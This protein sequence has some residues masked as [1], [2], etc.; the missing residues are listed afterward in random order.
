[1]RLLFHLI[2]A[3]EYEHAARALWKVPA[4]HGNMEFLPA[5]E[6]LLEH[7][8]EGDVDT[9]ISLLFAKSAI[10]FNNGVTDQA[11]S[12]L[13]DIINL[14]IHENSPL[15]AG[16][17]YHLL[18][19]HNMQAY[20][21]GKARH[22]GR[23]GLAH[24]RAVETPPHRVQNLRSI[25][26]SSEMLCGNQ[27]EVQRILEDI[28]ADPEFARTPE[29]RTLLEVIRGEIHLMRSE[30]LAAAGLLRA[31][32][33]V[34]P[35]SAQYWWTAN[36]SLGL[37]T[38]HLSDWEELIR[39]HRITLEGP[40]RHYANISQV[41]A[42]LAV[43]HHFLGNTSEAAQ[44]VQQ[45]EFNASQVKNDFDMVDAHRTLCE[46]HLILG[47]TER[48]EQVAL[49]G[50][51]T[52]LRHSATYPVLT[53]LMVLAE[54]AAAAG[55]ATRLRFLMTEARLL[56]ERGVLLRNRDV[57]LYHYHR[58]LLAEQEDPPEAE[59]ARGAARD[60]LTRELA[61]IGEPHAGAFLAVR[62]FG[63]VHRALV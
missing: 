24:Y 57:V 29:L 20:C 51:A 14:A 63:A 17:A 25:M 41:H 16:S 54:I 15:Y 60:L 1:M 43:A 52:G 40:S 53:L 18:T 12:L 26:A 62:S 4:L 8:T 31:T 48:A 36:L 46:C 47:N 7:F 6:L 39:L 28:R 32:L 3:E 33:G 11:D 56:L 35:R 44:R 59:A 9:Y 27:E 58:A 5:I 10:L 50:L 42:Q 23:N 13:K 45:A 49:A 19:A 61:N 37:V 21:F 55:D 30:Y 2:R 38:Y 22:C 34:L